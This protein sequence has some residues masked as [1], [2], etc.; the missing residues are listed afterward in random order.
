[1]ITRA[2]SICFTSSDFL[3]KT[4]GSTLGTGLTGTDFF[5][6][7]SVSFTTS[8]SFCLVCSGVSLL[9]RVFLGSTFSTGFSKSKASCFGCSLTSGF[10]FTFLTTFLGLLSITVLASSSL[11]NNV[12]LSLPTASSTISFAFFLACFS[13]LACSLAII[14]SACSGAL[15]I[16]ELNVPFLNLGL[17]NC[18]LDFSSFLAG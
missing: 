2:P 10:S 6:C 7:F 18:T 11:L 12:P 16:L 14:A 8:S 13:A 15:A 17:M 9:A 3:G 5:S 4:L 1:M